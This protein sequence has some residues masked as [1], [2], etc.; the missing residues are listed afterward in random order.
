[1]AQDDV[2]ILA[3]LGG[4]LLSTPFQAAMQLIVLPYK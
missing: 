1:M 3:S 4:D 2:Y